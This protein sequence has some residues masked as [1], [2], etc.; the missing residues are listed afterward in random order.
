MMLRVV[1]LRSPMSVGT[2]GLTIFGGFCGL[3]ALVQAAEDGLL[4]RP[5]WLGRL[6]LALPA[7][8]IDVVGS[9]FG[10]F[11]GGYTGVLLAI[12]AVPLWAKNYLLLGPL[13]LASAM[14]SAT[15]AITLALALVGGTGRRTLEQLRR[16]DMLM[17]V[18]ELVLLIRLRRGSGPVI[19]RPLREGR[20]GAIYRW[21]VLT[22]GIGTPLVLQASGSLLRGN[23]ERLVAGVT[24]SLILAGGF[25]LRY[26]MVMAGRASADDP[27]ATFEYT[28]RAGAI[29]NRE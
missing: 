23:S 17:L 15:A 24:S 9:L 8:A 27:Q 6:L 16:L 10:F 3:A 13:F 21:G 11:V 18:T 1:K 12:T 19:G 7:R 4:R 5:R 26:L 22:G 25:L 2:W 28:R 20:L 14:S 29:G